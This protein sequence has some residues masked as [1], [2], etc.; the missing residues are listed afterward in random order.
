MA[1]RL[2]QP[3]RTRR[4]KPTKTASSGS[5]GRHSSSQVSECAAVAKG[6]HTSPQP[7]DNS[8]G[9]ARANGH[10]HVDTLPRRT[11]LSEFHDLSSQSQRPVNDEGD[12]WPAHCS[13]RSKPRNETVISHTDATGATAKQSERKCEQRKCQR[14]AVIYHCAGKCL[15]HSNLMA[16][17]WAV[18]GRV[19]K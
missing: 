6:G 19:Y 14:G 8:L 13:E 1:L 5:R 15:P 16:L 12:S 18:Q 2:C 4:P 10:Q 17:P 3:P 7:H 11:H 9:V